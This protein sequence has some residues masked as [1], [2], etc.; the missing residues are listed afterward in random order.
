MNSHINAE[1]EMARCLEENAN[2]K[3]SRNKQSRN[4][5]LN[6]YHNNSYGRQESSVDPKINV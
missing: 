4:S 6:M 2:Y 1:E 5:S 3:C